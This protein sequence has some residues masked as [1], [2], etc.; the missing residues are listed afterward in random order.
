MCARVNHG[1]YR[2]GHPGHESGP[3]FRLPD[4]GNRQILV[5]Q[6]ANAVEHGNSTV[7]ITVKAAAKNSVSAKNTTSL[8]LTQFGDRRTPRIVF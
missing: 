1:L 6:A 4:V 5:E 2:E 8:T 3:R 7:C